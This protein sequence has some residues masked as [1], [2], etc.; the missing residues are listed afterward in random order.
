VKIH[1]LLGIPEDSTPEEVADA[2]RKACLRQHPDMG[3]SLEGMKELNQ[4]YDEWQKKVDP[5]NSRLAVYIRNI[6]KEVLESQ[7]IRTTSSFT[8]QIRGVVNATLTKTIAKKLELQDIIKLFENQLEE[9]KKRSKSAKGKE[10]MV[11]Q[12]SIML[13]E[14][15][16]LKNFLVD[17][18]KFFEEALQLV[19]FEPKESHYPAPYKVPSYYVTD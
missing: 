5:D 2:F 4:A 8:E 15:K 6:T 14:A 16:D 19:Q 11:A 10:Y 17:E 1:D 9:V 12:I 7:R 3:G 18:A 13:K